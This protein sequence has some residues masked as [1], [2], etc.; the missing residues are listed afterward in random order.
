MNTPSLHKR[1]IGSK[2]RPVWTGASSASS[3]SAN[4]SSQVASNAASNET[5]EKRIEELKNQN[6]RLAH[7]TVRLCT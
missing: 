5:H 4:V 1:R 6:K 3:T 7:F 2:A